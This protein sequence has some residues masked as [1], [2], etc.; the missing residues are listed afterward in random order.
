[1]SY[2]GLGGL[3]EEIRQTSRSIE[4]G[5][6]KT[7]KRLEVIEA[8]VNELY[9]KS[10]ALRAATTMSPSSARMGLGFVSSSIS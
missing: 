3:V 8:S 4:L 6:T 7:S 1:M 10:P 9:R 2:D 5:D